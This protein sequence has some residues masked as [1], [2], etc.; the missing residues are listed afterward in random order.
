MAEKKF[1]KGEDFSLQFC[2][3]G[4]NVAVL[5]VKGIVR[6]TL[7]RVQCGKFSELGSLEKKLRLHRTS[8][9]FEAR[10]DSENIIP[11]GCEYSVCRKFVCA[12][13]LLDITTDIAA[14]NFGRVGDIGL[15]QISFAGDGLQATLCTL[16]GREITLDNSSGSV[17][18][19]SDLPLRM[20][21][22]YPDGVSCEFSPGFDIWR[23]CAAEKIPG[24]DAE[25]LITADQSGIKLNRKVLMYDGTT[26]PE[27]RPWKFNTMLVWMSENERDKK[28]LPQT[29]EKVSG[30]PLSGS[31]R[32]EIRR[33]LRRNT[34]DFV[35]ISAMD[36]LCSDPAHLDRA[37]KGELLHRDTAEFLTTYIWANRLLAGQGGSFIIVPENGQFTSLAAMR[38]ATPLKQLAPEEDEN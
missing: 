27:K 18:L 19:G 9:G 4:K 5:T 26:E 20:Q 24:A 32:R 37:G 15:E 35:L 22:T 10:V 21:V 7:G 30:C 6:C 34:G 25:Y 12:D 2:G 8:D 29:G 1:I 14:V 31:Y 3:S 28:S 38:M 23:H 36:N 16:G 13:G 33:R 17:E 11:F